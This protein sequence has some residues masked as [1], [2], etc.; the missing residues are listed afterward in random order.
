MRQTCD[1]KFPVAWV[2]ALVIV[3]MQLV[4]IFP[5]HAG[6]R[7][8]GLYETGF[9]QTTPLADIGEVLRRTLPAPVYA[10]YVAKRDL[11]S[12]QVITPANE[13][14]Q[15]YVPGDYDGTKPCG[16]LVWVEPM[17]TLRFPSGWQGVL[18]AH[19]MIYV[20]AAESG[21]DRDVYSRR[22]PLA[23]TGLANIEAR[24]KTDP[25]RIYLGGFSGGGVTASLMAAAYAD[26]FSG[27]IFVATSAG[28][29]SQ[30]V[31]M[32]SPDRYRLMQ[33]RGRYVFLVGNEDPVN[34]VM[35]DRA[36]SSYEQLCILRVK[37]VEMFDKGHTNAGPSYLNYA[38]NYLDSPRDITSAQQTSC[39]NSMKT[40]HRGD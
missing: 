6:S 15:V 12:G 4:P 1:I 30:Q 11:P 14:W 17:D 31:P 24:Y 16:V 32:P 26:V 10:G 9:D 2:A 36:A 25:V 28:I 5:A 29:G 7:R 37:T 20:S 38:L 19:H 27:G 18:N 3:G 8:T 22:I 35:T 34:E 40:I 13:T 21:N 23:L 33:S 39:K